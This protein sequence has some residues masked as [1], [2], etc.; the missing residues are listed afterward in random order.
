[1]NNYLPL[2]QTTTLFAGLSAAELSTLL[3][4]LGAMLDAM[5]CR[6]GNL[7][8]SCGLPAVRKQEDVL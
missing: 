4:R 2:L 8:I 7:E 3:S 6:N 1:M 5:R